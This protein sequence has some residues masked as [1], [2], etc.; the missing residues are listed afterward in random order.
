MAIRVEVPPSAINTTIE[1]PVT[2]G[3]GEVVS[4]IGTMTLE[5]RSGEI[6][7]FRP[8]LADTLREAAAALE[9]ADTDEEEGVPGAA[10]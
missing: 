8:V 1:L 2:I 3:V 10:P 7:D 9:R 6:E 4:T 5:V